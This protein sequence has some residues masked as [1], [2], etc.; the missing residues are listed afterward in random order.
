MDSPADR[1]ILSASVPMTVMVPQEVPM[2]MEMRQAIR[3]MPRTVSLPGTIPR[4]MFAVSA[5]HPEAEATPLK[6]PASRKMKIMVRILSSPIPEAQI[7]IFSSKET[8]RFWNRATAM[9]AMNATTTDM[10]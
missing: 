5:A 3:K 1:E 6:A 9:A 4:S 7:F 10:T 8:V 2:A